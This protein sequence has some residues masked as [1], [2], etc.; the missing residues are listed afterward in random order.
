M[1]ADQLKTLR[2][3]HLATS[4]DDVIASATKKRWSPTQ[5]LEHLAAMAA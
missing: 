3:K 4:L 5:L 2:L 1:L